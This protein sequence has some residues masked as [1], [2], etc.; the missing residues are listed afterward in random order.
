MTSFVQNHF[1]VAPPPLDVPKVPSPPANGFTD[2]HSRLQHMYLEAAAERI[3]NLPLPLPIGEL[4]LRRHSILEV[5]KSLELP[6]NP[7]DDLIDQLGGEG[8]VCSCLNIIY[9]SD[10]LDSSLELLLLRNI[11]F[12]HMY[13]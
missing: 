13:I 12:L 11:C 3:K 2:Q 5:V 7:L 9:L 6:P 8:Q 1:P 4:L 10:F